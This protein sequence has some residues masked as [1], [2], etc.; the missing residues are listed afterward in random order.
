MQ[1]SA[2]FVGYIFSPSSYWLFSIFL[3]TTIIWLSF[4]TLFVLLGETRK[5]QL[6]ISPSNFKRRHDFSCFEDEWWISKIFENWN[7][8]IWRRIPICRGIPSWIYWWSYQVLICMYKPHL[9][10]I[11]YLQKRN[12]YSYLVLII[13]GRIFFL[14][15]A[16]TSGLRSL[17]WQHP[18]LTFCSLYVRTI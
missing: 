2:L 8:W 14:W 13:S 3:S 18:L 12:R 1:V 10:Y 11:I 6:V 5:Y 15:F 9:S 17:I 4:N 7:P 16:S